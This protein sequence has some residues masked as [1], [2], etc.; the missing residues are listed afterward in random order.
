LLYH[1]RAKKIF[2]FNKIDSFD[3]NG[4]RKL[5][6]RVKS[7][8]P[9]LDVLFVHEGLSRLDL[10]KL[11]L[12]IFSSFPII[13][14]YTKEPRK[15]ASPDPMILRVGS[16]VA[17]ASEKILKGLSERIIRTKIWGPSS[18]FGGQVVGIDHVLKDK[19]VVE[20]HAK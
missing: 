18:K 10:E 8:F 15:S 2:L 14:V 17:V 16:T 20:F 11:K 3:S 13:R 7:Q 4:L 12:K 19:D 1:S 9:G 6:A 5:R